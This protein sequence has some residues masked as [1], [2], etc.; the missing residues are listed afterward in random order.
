MPEARYM[1]LYQIINNPFR[2]LQERGNVK[3]EV[4]I[5]DVFRP[6]KALA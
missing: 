1:P 5:A 3:R 2:A 6:Q 4:E